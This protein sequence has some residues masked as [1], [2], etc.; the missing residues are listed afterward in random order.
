MD[1]ISAVAITGDFAGLRTKWGQLI[2]KYIMYIVSFTQF[3]SKYTICTTK[4]ENNY[5]I[6]NWV[7]LGQAIWLVYLHQMYKMGAF[8]R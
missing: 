6:A 7:E 1:R 5:L 8:H 2:C 4:R 3:Y